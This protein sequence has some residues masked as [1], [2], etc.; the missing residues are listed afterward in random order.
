MVDSV[1][2]KD[3]KGE[4]LPCD[5]ILYMRFHAFL[6][7]GYNKDMFWITEEGQITGIMYISSF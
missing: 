5:R 2:D 6:S 1:R 7:V 4:I 3:L